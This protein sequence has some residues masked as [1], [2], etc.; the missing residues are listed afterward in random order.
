MNGQLY[1]FPELAPQEKNVKTKGKRKTQ[2]QPATAAFLTA[3]DFIN[4]PY[5]GFRDEETPLEISRNGSEAPLEYMHPFIRRYA[6]THMKALAGHMNRLENLSRLLVEEYVR[7]HAAAEK[8]HPE[9]FRDEGMVDPENTLLVPF[10]FRQIDN[11]G[12]GILTEHI[13]ISDFKNPIPLGLCADLVKSL[14]LHFPTHWFGPLQRKNG[15]LVSD[16]CQPNVNVADLVPGIRMRHMQSHN[17]KSFLVLYIGDI[18]QVRSMP[19]RGDIYNLT[20]SIPDNMP[21]PFGTYLRLFAR[22]SRLLSGRSRSCSYSADSFYFRIYSLDDEGRDREREELKKAVQIGLD[23]WNGFIS[24]NM[25]AL[26]V[27]AKRNLENDE[28]NLMEL[29]HSG[30]EKQCT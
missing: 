20:S 1:L 13:Y 12:Q 19:S 23:S 2:V 3:D 15:C 9:W 16:S 22:T 8:K 30:E 11:D 14:D 24:E 10:E 17:G 29:I 25:E 28:Q 18:G 21:E 4:S 5:G 26:A 6:P 27:Q 7:L